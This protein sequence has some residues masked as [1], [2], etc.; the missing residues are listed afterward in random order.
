MSDI[1]KQD[2]VQDASHLSGKKG[3]QYETEKKQQQKNEGGDKQSWISAAKGALLAFK[4]WKK[5]SIYL[6]FIVPL[7]LIVLNALS[8]VL[9]YEGVFERIG[10]VISA[11]S[12]NTQF[13]EA[14]THPLNGLLGLYAQ[15]PLLAIIP[16]FV[17]EQLAYLHGG[18]A[19]YS[20]FWMSVAN[21]IVTV[22][23]VKWIWVVDSVHALVH[24]IL[25]Y[26]LYFIVFYVLSKM[27]K[28][29][30]WGQPMTQGERA[31]A[32]YQKSLGK[33]NQTLK[34]D[35]DNKKANKK[36]KDVSSFITKVNDDTPSL[37]KIK[38]WLSKKVPYVDGSAEYTYKF[39]NYSPVFKHF[40]AQRDSIRANQLASEMNARWEDKKRSNQQINSDEKMFSL[41]ESG[42]EFGE[43]DRDE[44]KTYIVQNIPYGFTD[45]KGVI[46]HNP[47]EI[48]SRGDTIGTVQRNV[49][50]LLSSTVILKNQIL[51]PIYKYLSSA[52]NINFNRVEKIFIS[53]GRKIYEAIDFGKNER[54]DSY[55][56]YPIPLSLQY[57]YPYI[58]DKDINKKVS[59][60]LNDYVT[61]QQAIIGCINEMDALLPSY[62]AS[63]DPVIYRNK[64]DD[65]QKIFMK[66]VKEIEDIIFMYVS[67]RIFYN[68][69]VSSK[70][71]SVLSSKIYQAIQKGVIDRVV[72]I[73]HS[74][75]NKISVFENREY[76]LTSIDKMQ[77]SSD[78]FLNLPD[79]Y[80]N[81]SSYSLFKNGLSTLGL[82]Q[83]NHVI[84]RVYEESNVKAKLESSIGF[85]MD[86]YRVY[87]SFTLI[88]AFLFEQSKKL[89]KMD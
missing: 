11:F 85:I 36:K 51:S 19:S 1:K 74:S 55:T 42:Y 3:G 56:L 46:F 67:E 39:T 31:L 4:Q 48:F 10:G 64:V 66:N 62:K 23:S 79:G 24:T 77:F 8:S 83:L 82:P 75:E 59:Q 34:S 57:D 88:S 43:T 21:S 63:M 68:P 84:D 72:S 61:T 89:E 86:E 40:F 81:L 6:F 69:G 25:A 49:F 27:T 71:K 29:D 50:V 45:D 9:Y 58:A 2:G 70:E 17:Y 5:A 33:S 18:P 73:G 52:H 76:Q 35:S 53:N 87:S 60:S 16:E 26:P 78:G 7:A 15:W 37:V 14:D 20:S 22:D 28:M 12:P 54:F 80:I 47:R 65:F 32:G 13:A 41:L 38:S 44:I 30:L